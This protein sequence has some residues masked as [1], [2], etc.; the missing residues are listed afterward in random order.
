MSMIGG[1]GGSL[2]PFQ[3]E[4]QKPPRPPQQQ[5][6]QPYLLLQQQAQLVLQLPPSPPPRQSPPPTAT[7]APQ[8]PRNGTGQQGAPAERNPAGRHASGRSQGGESAQEGRNGQTP[9]SYLPVLQRKPD[10][11]SD[12]EQDE[13]Q[14]K[15]EGGSAQAQDARAAAGELDCALLADELTAQSAEEGIFEVMMPDG[16]TL[17]VVV[18]LD[19]KRAQFLLSPSDEELAE[20]LRQGKMELEGH[21]GR[22]IN[23]DVDISVL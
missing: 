16:K 10:S 8:K 21:L 20:R 12:S 3:L 7:A 2:S 1:L 5:L 9:T 13:G 15:D 4:Q 17:G 14:G 6:P 23:K 11:G 18:R 22:R 19:D